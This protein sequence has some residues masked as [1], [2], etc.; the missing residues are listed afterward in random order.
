M[1]M[2]L[3]FKNQLRTGKSEAPTRDKMMRLGARCRSLFLFLCWACRGV[4]ASGARGRYQGGHRPVIT[5]DTQLNTTR[6]RP[7][8][9]RK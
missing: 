5:P 8:A 2:F 6:P 7:R 3:L 4:S 9:T 1:K